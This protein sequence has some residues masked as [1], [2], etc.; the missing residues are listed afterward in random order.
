VTHEQWV[1]CDA[2]AAAAATA[3]TDQVLGQVGTPCRFFS[4]LPLSNLLIQIPSMD[5]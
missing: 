1:M 3:V 5:G 2:V 4:G